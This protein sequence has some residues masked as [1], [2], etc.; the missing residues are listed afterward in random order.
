MTEML[1]KCPGISE[2]IEEERPSG[3]KAH[4]TFQPFPARLKSCP[5]KVL[6]FTQ[7]VKSAYMC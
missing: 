5:F 3:A 4:I 2:E 1:R 6:S 7:P